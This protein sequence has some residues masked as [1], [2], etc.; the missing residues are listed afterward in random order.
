MASPISLHDHSVFSMTFGALKE[1][2]PYGV[3]RG[4]R[5]VTPVNLYEAVSVGTAL[6]MISKNGKIEAEKLARLPD[7]AA[8]N[9][10]RKLAT[11]ATNSRKR[12]VGR[13]EFVRDALL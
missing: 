9:E 8:D 12:V 11:G 10:L 4:A 5:S 13:I 1:H 3:V 7:I 2:M 6:A